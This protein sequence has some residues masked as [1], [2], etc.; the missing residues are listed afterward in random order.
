MIVYRKGVL[1][2]TRV[3]I[4]PQC[5]LPQLVTAWGWVCEGSPGYGL[6]TQGSHHGMPYSVRQRSKVMKH[7]LCMIHTFS[8][9]SC[10]HA[11][12]VTLNARAHP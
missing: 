4:V 3:K 9:T 11:H 1:L 10:S 2:H 12:I 5:H 8:I 6:E 7:T